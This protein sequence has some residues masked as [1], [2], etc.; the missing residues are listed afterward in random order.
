[1]KD[2]VQTLGAT[3]TDRDGESPFSRP[4]GDSSAV[5]Q[6]AVIV[7]LDG[8]EHDAAAIALGRTLQSALDGRLLLAH[9]IPPAPPGQGMVEYEVIVRREGRQLLARAAASQHDQ[10]DIELIDPAPAAQGLTRL[11]AGCDDCVLVLGSS[12]RG[13]VGRIVPGGVAS[14][15][16]V[17][18]PCAIAVAPVDYAEHRPPSISRVGVAYDGTSEADRALAKAAEAATR[19]K[20]PLRLYHAIHEIPTD[21][22]WDAYRRHMHDFARETLERGLMQLPAELEG[23]STV[24]EGR[25]AEVISRVA[26]NDGVALLYVGSRGYGPLRE[27]LLGGVGGGLLRTARCPLMV[28]PRSARAPVP[29]RA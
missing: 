6:Q 11:A 5:Q 20:V 22:A 10:V 25:T 24:L 19:L 13:P 27:A 16:L 9:V 7:G 18:A 28:V 15:L 2:G 1:M 17:R 26:A 14:E 12:H 8:R 29:R 23:T 21:P 3:A 4:S